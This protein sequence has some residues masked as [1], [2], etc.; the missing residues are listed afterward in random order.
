MNTGDMASPPLAASATTPPAG[1]VDG[2]LVLTQELRALAHGH[3][4]LAVLESR[5]CLHAALRMALMA[6]VTAVLLV[7]AWL[8]LLAAGMHALVA[9]GVAPVLAMVLFAAVNLMLALAGATLMRRSLSRF[10]LPATLRTLNPG[11]A[12][13][14]PGGSG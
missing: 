8:V 13:A 7:S 5:L 4:E 11:A 14:T 2:V 9:I 6:I 1:V 10:G 3:L 12:A